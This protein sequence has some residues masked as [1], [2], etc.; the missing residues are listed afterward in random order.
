MDSTRDDVHTPSKRHKGY[1]GF[2]TPTDGHEQQPPQSSP[3]PSPGQA[4]AQYSAQ[5]AYASPQ[6]AYGA[7]QQFT[8]PQQPYASPHQPFNTPVTASHAVGPVSGNNGI[9]GSPL[10]TAMAPPSAPS[11]A[12]ELTHGGSQ[13]VSAASTPVRAHFADASQSTPVRAHQPHSPSPASAAAHASAVTV[14]QASPLT[15]APSP[16]PSPATGTPG[17]V[18]ASPGGVGASLGGVGPSPGGVAASPGVAGSMHDPPCAACK[19]LRRKCTRECIFLPYFPRDDPEKFARVHKVFGASNVSKMLQEL[20]LHQREDAVASLDSTSPRLPA[21]PFVFDQKGN[22]DEKQIGKLADYAAGNPDR[23]PKIVAKLEERAIRELRAERFN[24]LPAVARSY[25]KLLSSCQSSLALLAWSVLSVVQKLL[26]SKRV[27]V[28]V[29]GCDLLAD[30][31]DC[32]SDAAYAAPIQKLCPTLVAMAH[33]AGS[34]EDSRAARSSALRA[35]A[36]VILFVSYFSQPCDCLDQLLAAVLDNYKPH[37]AGAGDEGA[38]AAEKVRERTHEALKKLTLQQQQQQQGGGG[39][40]KEELHQERK[41]VTPLP[42]KQELQHPEVA[43]LVAVWALAHMFAAAVPLSSQQVLAHLLLYLSNGSHWADFEA[44][45]NHWVAPL[46]QELQHPE[47][48]ALVAVWALAHM[49]AAAVSL[50]SQQ[51]LAHLL[52][53]LSNGSHW[54]APASQGDAAAAAAAAAGAGAEAGA[55]GR[56]GV[57]GQ[58]LEDICLALRFLATRSP[59]P[60]KEERRLLLALLAAVIRHADSSPALR[61]PRMRHDALAVAGGLQMAHLLLA[62]GGKETGGQGAGGGPG[63]GEEKREISAG[64]AGGAV[65]MRGGPEAASEVQAVGDLLRILKRSIVEEKQGGGMD[66][67]IIGEGQVGGGV[68]FRRRQGE[69]PALQEQALKLLVLVTSLHAGSPKDRAALLLDDTAVF[70]ESLPSDP[71]GSW[72]TLVAAEAAAAVVVLPVAVAVERNEGEEG[73][74]GDEGE[75]GNRKGS[76][77]LGSF[78]D[79]ALLSILR[80]FLH[81][82]SETRDAAHHL[83]QLL[84]R[85]PAAFPPNDRD[86]YG[87]VIAASAVTTSA[88][89]A[90]PLASIEDIKRPP[91]SPSPSQLPLLLSALWLQAAMPSTAPKSLCALSSTFHALLPCLSA[92]PPPPSSPASPSSQSLSSSLLQSF[93]LA[94]SLR[95]KALSLPSVAAQGA[96]GRG[97]GGAGAEVE[98]EGGGGGGEA[99]WTIGPV[100]RRSVFTVATAMLAGLA[101]SLGME[102]VAAFVLSEEASSAALANPFHVINPDGTLSERRPPTSQSAFGS[103]ADS[104]RAAAELAGASSKEEEVQVQLGEKIAAAVVAAFP[105]HSVEPALLLAPFHPSDSLALTPAADMLAAVAADS[106]APILPSFEDLPAAIPDEELFRASSVPDLA[107]P[108]QGSNDGSNRGSDNAGA[109]LADDKAGASDGKKTSGKKRRADPANEGDPRVGADICTVATAVSTAGGAASAGEG[110]K[111][112]ARKARGE[113]SEAGAHKEEGG[114]KGKLTDERDE[115]EEDGGEQGEAEQQGE[116]SS[117]AAEDKLVAGAED[118]ELGEDAEE[119]EAEEGEVPQD[120][121]DAHGFVEADAELSPRELLPQLD[122]EAASQRRIKAHKLVA[123]AAAAAARSATQGKERGSGSGGGT[124]AAAAAAEWFQAQVV[125]NC[126][127]SMSS[128]E[129]ERVIPA[130]SIAIYNIH[131]PSSPQQPA[132]STT[133][134]APGAQPGGRGPG[135]GQAGGRGAGGRGAGRGGKAGSESAAAH[136]G[137]SLVDHLKRSLG[138]TWRSLLLPPGDKQETDKDQKKGQGRKPKG[139]NQQQGQQGQQGGKEEEGDAEWE[140]GSPVVLIVSASAVRCVDLLR[141]CKG[142]GRGCRVAKLFAKHL[143]VEEQVEM[144]K[145][146]VHIAAGTPNRLLKLLSSGALRL[147]CLRVVVLDMLPSPKAFTLLSMPDVRVEFWELYLKHLHES[148][149]SESAVLALH[150]W[151]GDTSPP[152]AGGGKKLPGEQMKGKKRAA[153]GARREEGE[154]EGEGG[155]GGGA[156]DAG[157]TS[158]GE[159]GLQKKQKKRKASKATAGAEMS[160]AVEEGAGGAARGPAGDERKGK[161]RR[162]G[163]RGR[164][165]GGGG[166]GGGRRGGVGGGGLVRGFGGRGSGARGGGGRGGRGRGGGG[167][168]GRGRGGGGKRSGD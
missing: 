43:A 72:A 37:A 30:F 40:E 57:A 125:A 60:T 90:H 155:G 115:A 18:A 50:S 106:A 152:K 58:L 8:S 25:S 56:G 102:E 163:G 160:G 93:Q 53:Y 39:K 129:R 168:G 45:Q 61:S 16:S 2:P 154:E 157:D 107:R 83:L 99:E 81:P 3:S 142:V 35:I 51:V 36:A 112:R 137:P 33:E 67:N 146:P 29:L 121:N 38:A 108:G 4:Q 124:A 6:Q 63:I 34:Q 103:P 147:A 68:S 31:V 148:V 76:G 167:R 91:L 11:V 47:V 55:A 118:A 71:W 24:S 89:A 22:V 87:L 159:E 104:E 27:D 48:A 69:Q 111:K 82:H 138:A 130:S 123:E 139:Q 105:G 20:P 135:G 165:G 119:E 133:T 136:V 100:D 120:D 77:T 9:G 109:A 117:A 96:D 5:Q 127:R 144:L 145:G 12:L 26:Q 84:L 23:I 65:S 122:A 54:A 110:K 85:G 64:G 97:G 164:R 162:E 78:P 166:R 10:T 92:P 44:P 52:L 13:P 153:A 113:G 79:A 88:S 7:P 131:S 126:G 49:F 28:R 32:Q 14:V 75:E 70:L 1:N 141:A 95:R 86:C 21:V 19:S 143:K 161:G 158:G 46:I 101:G 66:D 41:L 128:V 116:M 150:G 94:L 149:L 114:E 156:E 73:G 98:E 80:A 15:V 42:S 62:D 140:A 134:Q 59:S 17:A 151:T 74:E 132:P